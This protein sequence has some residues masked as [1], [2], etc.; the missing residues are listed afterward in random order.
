MK[1]DKLAVIQL[2]VLVNT[3]NTNLKSASDHYSFR[4]SFCG[5]S[6]WKFKLAQMNILILLVCDAKAQ[7]G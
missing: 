6:G 2:L 4:I 3:Q 7:R 5:Q 1:P